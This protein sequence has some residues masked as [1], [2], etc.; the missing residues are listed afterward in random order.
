MIYR[1]I[2]ADARDPAGRGRLRVMIPAVTG[3]SI[4]EWIWPIV[5][6]SHPVLPPPGS[7]VWVMFE[8][9][10]KD[11]PVWLGGAELTA[12]TRIQELEQRV[13]AL[14]QSV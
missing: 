6:N 9:G 3:E 5:T 14:E 2:V 1:A 10:D 7:Q 8:N 12:E 11:V 4:S 13:S